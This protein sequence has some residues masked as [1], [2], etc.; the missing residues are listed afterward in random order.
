MKIY[1]VFAAGFLVKIV[2]VLRDYCL[3]KA[4]MFQNR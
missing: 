4:C 2:N 3:D 1:N